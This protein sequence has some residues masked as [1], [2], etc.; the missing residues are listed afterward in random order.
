MDIPMNELVEYIMEC[1]LTQNDAAVYL[2]LLKHRVSN[3]SEISK[4]TGIQRPRVY[5]S[6]KR[7][8]ERGFVVQ[9]LGKKRPQYMISDS[10]FLVKELQGQIESK[11]EARDVIKEQ[12]MELLPF[13]T[14]KGIFFFNNDEALRLKLQNLMQA[15]KK[16]IT[17]MAICPSFVKK[18]PLLSSELLGK[19]SFEG[20]KISLLLNINPKNWE[21]CR[22][23]FNKKINIYHYPHLKQI[24]TMIHLIDDET[25]FISAFKQRRNKIVLEYGI[26]FSGDRNL[27]T[28]FE[29]LIQGF[30]SQSIS[31]KER[32]D[33]LE[34]SVIH[35]TETLKGIYGIKE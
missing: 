18:E 32:F 27:I 3:P 29:F 28:A 13:P 35:P 1:N 2:W 10:Q 6:L 33:Q 25:L 9:D 5:D 31:L 17:I 8:M 26:F 24:S 21:Y 12:L 14:E 15:S 34:K 16:K 22:D 23:L 19:K 4:G 7:L 20:Q 30:I 11:T